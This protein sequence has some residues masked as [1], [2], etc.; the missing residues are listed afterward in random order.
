MKNSHLEISR[1]FCP[2]RGCPF[3]WS[4]GYG[5]ERIKNNGMDFDKMWQAV[6]CVVFAGMGAGQA[7][8]FL[9]DAL[10]AAV[11]AHDIFGVIDRNGEPRR[12]VITTF[13]PFESV[14][15]RGRF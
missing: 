13:R 14:R 3:G 5:G 4:I 2:N 10:N 6:M 9:P 7:F 1:D 11:A 12:G 8:G 15:F